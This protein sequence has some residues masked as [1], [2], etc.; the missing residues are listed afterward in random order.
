MSNISNPGSFAT[1]LINSITEFEVTHIR[2]PN[3]YSP[4]EAV[5]RLKGPSF[6]EDREEVYWNIVKLGCRYYVASQSLLASRVYLEP[7]ISPAG[8]RFVRTKPNGLLDD[9]LLSLPQF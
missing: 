4:V 5:Q 6:N 2:K 3:P 7:Q 8:T 1:G 9:N